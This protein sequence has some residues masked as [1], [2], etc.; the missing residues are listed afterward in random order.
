MLSITGDGKTIELVQAH[1]DARS[2]TV[3]DRRRYR[4]SDTPIFAAISSSDGE[5]SRPCSR[6]AMAVSRSREESRDGAGQR[7]EAAEIIEHVATDSVACERLEFD[8]SVAIIPIGG[9]DQSGDACRFKIFQK[10]AGR[11]APVKLPCEHSDLRP[12][13]G[14]GLFAFAGRKSG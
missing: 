5:A 7:I 8:V 10:D 11:A 4:F 12:M 9:F 2:W 3:C 1:G 14:D 13:I 6:G